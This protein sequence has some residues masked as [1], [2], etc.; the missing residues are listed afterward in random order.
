MEQLLLSVEIW[1]RDPDRFCIENQ[2][3]EYWNGTKF[4]EGKKNAML[5]DTPEKA[6]AEYHK[7]LIR[8]YSGKATKKVTFVLP[9]AIEVYGDPNL[10]PEE[11]LDYL[12]NAMSMQVDA[13]TYGNGPHGNLVLPR[14]V[15]DCFKRRQKRKKDEPT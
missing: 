10:A 15:W 1:R 2:D 12:E 5:Y 11:V 9:I 13:D 14:I 8:E 6:T 3:E 7:I 4:V